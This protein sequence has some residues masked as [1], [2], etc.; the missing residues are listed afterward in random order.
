MAKE[1]VDFHAVEPKH[2]DVHAWLINWARWCHG[3]GRVGVHP[4][5]QGV[6]PSQQW[7]AVEIT[8][9]VDALGAQAAEKAVFRLPGDNRTAIRWSY[10]YR[11]APMR[12]ARGL[13]V[14]LDGLQKLVR[15][16]RQMLCNRG[17]S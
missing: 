14:S 15:D 9:T 8:T 4:M 13:G 17:M 10:V 5:F 3:T 2:A 16:G 1:Y 6:K 11:T 12:M 7:E